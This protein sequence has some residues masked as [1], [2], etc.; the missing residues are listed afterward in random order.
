MDNKCAIQSC[1]GKDNCQQFC[2]CDCHGKP[3]GTM[4]MEKL[5]KLI[6][7]VVDLKDIKIGQH[8]YFDD[9]YNCGFSSG[10]I[11]LAQE[12]YKIITS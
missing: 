11:A 6:H 3:K 2:P 1:K 10:Q 7:R 4:D 8:D 9:P 12:I 5:N